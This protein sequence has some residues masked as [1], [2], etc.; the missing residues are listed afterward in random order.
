MLKPCGD[1]NILNHNT[2]T[3]EKL[4][5][6]LL[7]ASPRYLNRSGVLIQHTRIRYPVL[8]KL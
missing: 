8:N 3:I 7:A 6:G 5:S 4:E 1:R 2:D